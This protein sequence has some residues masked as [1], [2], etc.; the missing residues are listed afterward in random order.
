MLSLSLNTNK[1]S[2]GRLQ[3]LRLGECVGEL[4]LAPVQIDIDCETS[5]TIIN[6]PGST[7]STQRCI[8]WRCIITK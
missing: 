5:R 1:Q 6:L 7:Q 2:S 3:L 8:V 4:L